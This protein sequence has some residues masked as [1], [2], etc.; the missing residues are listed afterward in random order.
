VDGYKLN[1]FAG[2]II[3]AVLLIMGI[4][5]LNH[6]LNIP[7]EPERQAYIIEGVEPEATEQAAA[8][9][10]AVPVES[11]AMRLAAADAV[12][13]AKVF[14]KCTQCHTIDAGGR[15]LQGPNLHNVVGAA[16][17]GKDFKYSKN[18]AAHGGNWTYEALDAWLEKP[19]AFISGTKMTLPLKKAKDRANV[20]LFLMQNTENAPALP[21]VDLAPVEPVAPVA[22]EAIETPEAL[23][24]EEMAPAEASEE[25]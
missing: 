8:P 19:S 21:V 1:K 14:K 22:P 2:A 11:L 17:G 4:K 24:T 15:N 23:E 7:D 3:L 6:A 25:G 10:V 12:A 16:I 20:I 18:V 5:E 9:V 13:G